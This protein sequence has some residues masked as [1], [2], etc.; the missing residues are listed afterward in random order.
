M[1]RYNRLVWE[2][3]ISVIGEKYRNQDFS[4]GRCDM[5]A[6]FTRLQGQNDDVASWSEQTVNKIKS[7]LVKSLVET[8]YLDS[9]RSEVLNPI[10]LSEEL[11]RGIRANGDY[12]ALPAFNCFR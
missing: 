11:E 7:V 4:Y 3:M 6:F 5:N 10:F 2:F 9:F 12:E 8:G 1:M